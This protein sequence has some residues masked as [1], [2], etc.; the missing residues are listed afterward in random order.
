LLYSYSPYHT[1]IYLAILLT[2]FIYYKVI[3]LNISFWM[4][5]FF[6][7]H[8]QTSCFQSTWTFYISQTFPIS[9]PLSRI[10]FG[11]MFF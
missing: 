4:T 1:N 6:D 3:F 8:F 2:I 9:N 7:F 10:S 11:C 5:R